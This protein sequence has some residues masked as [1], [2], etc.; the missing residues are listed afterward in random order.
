MIKSLLSKL[1][2]FKKRIRWNYK[3]QKGSWDYMGNEEKRYNTIVDFIKETQI[4]K[5]SILDL[6]CGY[7]ALN[8]YLETEKYGSFLGID[9]SSIAIQRAKNANYLNSEFLSADIHQF[10]PKQKFDIIIF[11]EVLY[12]LDNQL[13]IVEKYA[14][15]FNQTGYF[16]F[17][18]YGIRQDLIDSLE[19]KYVLVK[20]EVIS[21]SETIFW[22]IC[23]YRNK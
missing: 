4:N 16:I 22:G 1:K 10:Q 9:L 18:F 8:S 19:E 21:Q 20:K 15:Y 5:P 3:Y 23:L 17:S 6:G 14:N 7:G 2:W 13:E 11:N 12:Y